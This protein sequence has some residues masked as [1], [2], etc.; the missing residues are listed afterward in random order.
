MFGPMKSLCS[1]TM[2]LSVNQTGNGNGH[3]AHRQCRTWQLCEDASGVSAIELEC[4]RLAV[5]G[6]RRATPDDGSDAETLCDMVPAAEVT[7][8]S[9]FITL[10]YCDNYTLITW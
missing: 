5:F 7:N 10:N 2:K 1:R 3:H 6:C 4:Q 9:V 8:R